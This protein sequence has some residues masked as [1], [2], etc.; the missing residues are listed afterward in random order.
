MFRDH[1]KSFESQR[2]EKIKIKISTVQSVK[3]RE[4]ISKLVCID[5][6]PHE[7]AKC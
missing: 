4:K 1:E 6:K 2:P 5:K 3:E 7:A